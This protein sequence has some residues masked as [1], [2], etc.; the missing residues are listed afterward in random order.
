MSKGFLAEEFL[1]HTRNEWGVE[2][3]YWLLDVRFDEDKTRVLDKNI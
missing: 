1:K 2:S 3:M